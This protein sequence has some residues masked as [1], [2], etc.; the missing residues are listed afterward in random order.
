MRK[1][2]NIVL[3]DRRFQVPRCAEGEVVSP[4]RKTI[5]E[6]RVVLLLEAG[7]EKDEDAVASTR[8]GAS[9]K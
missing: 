9:D 5:E 2:R 8:L 3:D 7:F 4:L 6:C 1:L